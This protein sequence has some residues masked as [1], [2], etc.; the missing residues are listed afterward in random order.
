[1]TKQKWLQFGWEVLI[2]P[3]YSP[4][5]AA[6]DAH[7]FWTLQH[8]LNGKKKKMHSLNQLSSVAQSCLTLCDPMDYSMPGLPVHHQLQEFT[9]TYVHYVGDDIQPSYPLLSPSPPAFNFFQHQGLFKW[10]SSSHHVAKVLEFQL[11]HQSF[12]WTFR[13]DSLSDCI[14]WKTV[15]ST[16]KSSLFKKIKS[17]G[18]MKL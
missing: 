16:W 6:S 12:Q 15:K 10:V 4:N 8:S 2:H 3:P 11:Q 7:L 5:I 1:M 13:T 17:L 18:K 9:Q 14:P